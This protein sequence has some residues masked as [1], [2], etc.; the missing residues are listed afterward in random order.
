MRINKYAIPL[1]AVALIA[2]SVIIA[3]ATGT[4]LTSGKEIVDRK[5]EEGT[6]T[7]DDIRGW[8]TLKEVA[9]RFGMPLEY[10]YTS[11]GLDLAKFAPETELRELEEEVSFE[12]EDV[13][14]VARRF[15]AGEPAELIVLVDSDSEIAEEAPTPISVSI[16]NQ[17]PAVAQEEGSGPTE[18]TASSTSVDIKGRMTLKEIA[19][20]FKLPLAELIEKSGL[21][22]DVDVK[23]ALRD[24]KAVAPEGWEIA[25]VRDA[26]AEILGE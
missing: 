4:W 21:P 25:Q 2:L 15:I 8:M 6:M 10:L 19:S 3:N 13:R 11:L 17:V 7:S 18:L 20:A 24:L 12:T 23:A 9:E 22:A 14:E 1:L 16:P 5:S 26:V